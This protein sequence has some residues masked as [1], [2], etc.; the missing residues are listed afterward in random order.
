MKAIKAKDFHPD[1][2]HITWPWIKRK[3]VTTDEDLSEMYVTFKG[4]RDIVWCWYSEPKNDS[5][6]ETVLNCLKLRSECIDRLNCLKK[7]ESTKN[8]MINYKRPLWMV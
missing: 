4:K 7:E 5:E 2:V 8:N 6:E 3:A 1:R